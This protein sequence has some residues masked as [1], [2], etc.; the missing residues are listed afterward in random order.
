MHVF[1]FAL[2]R[3]QKNKTGIYGSL[4]IFARKTRFSSPISVPAIVRQPAP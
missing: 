1:M 4:W 2:G 3:L